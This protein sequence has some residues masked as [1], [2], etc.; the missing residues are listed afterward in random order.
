MYL[1]HFGLE[2]ARDLP[3]LAELLRSYFLQAPGETTLP[4]EIYAAI[5]KGFTP[6]INAA[7]TLV[8]GVSMALLLLVARLVRFGDLR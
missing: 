2:S 4:V 7:S 1:D 3:G 6:E 5:R 8:I